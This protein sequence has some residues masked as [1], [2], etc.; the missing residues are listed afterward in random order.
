MAAPSNR[1]TECLGLAGTFK[2][3]LVQHPKS[4][5]GHL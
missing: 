1:I 5:K 2:V 4:D 3:H